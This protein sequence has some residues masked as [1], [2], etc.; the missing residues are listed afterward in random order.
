[1]EAQGNDKGQKYKSIVKSIEKG[2]KETNQILKYELLS[3]NNL[4]VAQK[5]T[6]VEE[7]KNIV[8]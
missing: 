4:R 1:M 5:P 3:Q 2:L 7:I 8:S 6:V